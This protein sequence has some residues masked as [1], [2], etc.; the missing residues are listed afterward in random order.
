M[1]K[2]GGPV[3]FLDIYKVLIGKP[4]DFLKDREMGCAYVSNLRLTN[5]RFCI[6]LMNQFL[7]HLMISSRVVDSKVL[8]MTIQFEYFFF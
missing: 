4:V 7:A 6:F 1:R 5:S 2:S 3:D 8:R